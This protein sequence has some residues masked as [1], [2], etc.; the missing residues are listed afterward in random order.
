[1]S[2]ATHEIDPRDTGVA[3][4]LINASQQ[5]GGAIGTALLNTIAATA[6]A[7]WIRTHPG[8]PGQVT[9]G[10]VHGY[11]VGAAWA[12]GIL[13]LAALIVFALG[14][15]ARPARLHR[16]LRMRRSRAESMPVRGHS[17]D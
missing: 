9:T 7:G 5:V 13:L 6:A 3:S 15:Q 1:M 11:A 4:G 14:H 17:P 16:R 2:L 8:G 12:A 10:T